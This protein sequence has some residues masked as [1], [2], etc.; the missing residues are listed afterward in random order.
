MIVMIN[1]LNLFAKGLEMIF[2]HDTNYLI[3]NFTKDLKEIMKGSPTSNE[4]VGIIINDKI[5]SE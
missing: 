1:G 5:S 4:T 2:P 3:E